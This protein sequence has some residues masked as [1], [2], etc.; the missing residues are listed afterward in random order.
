MDQYFVTTCRAACFHKTYSSAAFLET[1]IKDEL[2]AESLSFVLEF[3]ISDVGA[4]NPQ[5]VNPSTL[6][7][8]AAANE[9][10]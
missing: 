8:K 5:S 9:K 3:L 2:R 1:F 4:F 6:L 7:T 10:K